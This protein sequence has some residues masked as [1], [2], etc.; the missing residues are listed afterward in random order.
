MFR[1]HCEHINIATR[2]TTV[3]S[4][5]RTRGADLH[6]FVNNEKESIRIEIGLVDNVS[7]GILGGSTLIY[8]NSVHDSRPKCRI[9]LLIGPNV[10][11]IRT[12]KPLQI[13]Q[14]V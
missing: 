10:I 1:K 2:F 13:L 11:A 9:T 5:P 14:I 4:L 8:E 6:A 7:V 3:P 12:L